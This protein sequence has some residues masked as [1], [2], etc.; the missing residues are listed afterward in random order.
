M[1][2]LISQ[3]PRNEDRPIHDIGVT[4]R[5]TKEATSARPRH[6]PRRE[7]TDMV[8]LSKNILKFKRITQMWPFR[9]PFKVLPMKL[10]PPTFL[11]CISE[12]RLNEDTDNSGTASNFTAAGHWYPPDLMNRFQSVSDFYRVS[13]HGEVTRVTDTYLLEDKGYLK[14]SRPLTEYQRSTIFWANAIDGFVVADGLCLPHGES[15]SH[16]PSYQRPIDL[17]LNSEA[18]ID[19]VQSWSRQLGLEMYRDLRGESSLTGNLSIIIGLIAFSCRRKNLDSMLI[20]DRAWDNYVWRGHCHHHGRRFYFHILVVWLTSLGIPERGL[21][22]QVFL[23][24]DNT[25][26]ST[27]H[28]LYGLERSRK[29]LL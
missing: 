7:S 22:V 24:P 16:L 2:D 4:S 12:I 17:H 11:F 21:T 26:T 15:W 10:S 13:I 25:M 27:T 23:D 6:K 8:L 9:E 1:E 19:T 20:H 29:M 5:H 18:S 14:D 28:N 3:M